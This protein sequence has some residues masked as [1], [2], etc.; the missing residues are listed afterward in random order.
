MNEGSIAIKQD[1]K[2]I[3]IEPVVLK[4]VGAGAY[5]TGIS[6]CDLT[7]S[8]IDACGFSI[9]MLLAFRNGEQPLYVRAEE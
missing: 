7:Q 4:Y 5:V 8:M 1:D 3:V 2:S 6:A 9:E